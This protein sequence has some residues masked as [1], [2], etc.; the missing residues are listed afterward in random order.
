[1]KKIKELIIRLLI[2]PTNEEII[3]P[4]PKMAITIGKDSYEPVVLK[5]ETMKKNEIPEINKPNIHPIV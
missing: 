5:L 1:M 4:I 3:I 2:S